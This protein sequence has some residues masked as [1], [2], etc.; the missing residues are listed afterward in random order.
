VRSKLNVFIGRRG[1]KAD[2][3]PMG[4]TNFDI[5][6]FLLGRFIFFFFFSF[7]FFSSFFLLITH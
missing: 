6:S 7:L 3:A 2:R 1:E 4:M 5:E